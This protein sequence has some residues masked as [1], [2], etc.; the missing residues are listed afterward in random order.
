MIPKIKHILGSKECEYFSVAFLYH[1]IVL[2]IL[3]VTFSVVENP[4]PIISILVQNDA[5]DIDTKPVEIPE[6][7]T[8]SD[9]T[10][11]LNN[12]IVPINESSLS[13]DTKIEIPST[14]ELQNTTEPQPDLIGQM[15]GDIL[16]GIGNQVGKGTSSEQSTGGAL[17]R[18]TAE[19]I[20][21]NQ[22]RNLHVLWLFDAS[23][24]LSYQRQY[25][26]DRVDKILTELEF[27]RNQSYELSHSIFSFGSSHNKLCDPTADSTILKNAISSII[28]DLSGTENTFQTIYLLANEYAKKDPRLMFIVFTDEVGDDVDWLDKASKICRQKG[29]SVYVVGSPAPFGKSKAQFKY[30][31]PDPNFDQRERWVEIQQGPE[32]LFPMILDIHTLPIDD[33]VLDSGYGPFGLCSLCAETGGIYFSVHPNR[34]NTKLSRKDISPLSSNIS[35]FFD[36]DVMIRY[37]PDY[38]SPSVQTKE[39][40]SHRIKGALVKASSLRLDINGEQTLNFRAFTEG[41]FVDELN[42]AQRFSAQVEPKINQIYSILNEYEKD[43]GQLKDKRWIVSYYL[44]MGRILATKCRVELYNLILAEAKTGLKK[45]DPKTNSWVLYHS[46]KVS[47]SNSQINKNHKQALFYLN[48]VIENY[49]DTPWAYVATEEIKTPFGYEWKENYIEPPKMGGGGGN[50]N[51]P[52]D[53][54]I[55]KLQPKPQRKIEKI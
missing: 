23:L 16:S 55:K 29:A 12:N 46:D 50:N 36:S 15:S 14:I 8:F 20:S 31:D 48:Y 13:V 18:L 43:I 35:K 27:S 51:P 19:I 40:N 6:I 45:K 7:E 5:V 37:N 21:N 33:E 38:R 30:V 41:D 22:D 10:T 28:L 3:A 24:S 34:S 17:D 52:K 2:S 9:E 49:P 11:S 4:E 1:C 42:K 26:R 44:A 39:I 47:T 54:T 25:I 53:D 32:T